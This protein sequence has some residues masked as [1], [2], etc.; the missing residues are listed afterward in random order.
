MSSDEED[1]DEK[2]SSNKVAFDIASAVL[3]G[4]IDNEGFLTDDIF[5]EECKR[6]LGSLQPH[7]D[8]VVPYEDIIEKKRNVNDSDNSESDSD[9]TNENENVSS[10]G[11]N[12]NNKRINDNASDDNCKF[13]IHFHLFLNI[14]L[15]TIMLIKMIQL[16]TIPT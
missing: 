12:I 6:H 9:V 5:D 1:C 4:N 14:I 8:S 2:P 3:F 13:I 10:N 16:L 15:Q 7:L 11:N